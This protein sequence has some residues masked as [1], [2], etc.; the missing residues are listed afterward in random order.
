MVFLCILGTQ[1]GFQVSDML[2]KKHFGSLYMLLEPLDIA[3]EMFQAGHI[4]DVEHDYVTGSTRRYERLEKLLEL[5]RGN[6]ELYPHF[7][8]V[9]QAL[10]Y[11]SVLDTLKMRASF[12]LETCKSLL[13]INLIKKTPLMHEHFTH[14][15]C[16]VAESALWIQQNFTYLQEELPPVHYMMTILGESL[17]SIDNYDMH[18]ISG[19]MPKTAKL[20]KILLR[21]GKTTSN[22]FLEKIKTD[23]RR[24]DMVYKMKERSMNLKERG[25]HRIKNYHY[26]T[27]L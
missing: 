12:E 22:Y 7:V 23:L 9:L 6:T 10:G 19:A 3:D 2:L 4:S 11:F 27:S 24:E 18:D 1:H 14:E 15:L 13:L 25:T 20:L 17:D 16:F 5:L 21:K 26:Y 8:N